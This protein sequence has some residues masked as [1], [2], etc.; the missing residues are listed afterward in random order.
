MDERIIDQDEFEA[1][2]RKLNLP[3]DGKTRPTPE[4]S[5]RLSELIDA[6]NRW[7]RE[8]EARGRLIPSEERWPRI[9]KWLREESADEPH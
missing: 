8:N 7:H 3:T 6:V 2:V 9:L 1:E 4:Q 5:A